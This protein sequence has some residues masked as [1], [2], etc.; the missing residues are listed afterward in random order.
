MKAAVVRQECDGQVEIK[1]IPLR[2]LEAGEALVEVEYCGLCHTD[3]HVAA[4]DFGKK[5]GRVIG[6]E[7]IGIVTKIAPDVKSLKIGD[8]VSIAWFHAGCGSCE[9]CISGQETFCRNVLNSGYSVDGGMAEQCIVKADYAVKV[10]EGLDPAQAT[11][12]TCAGVTTYKGIKVADTK[13]GQWLAVFGIGGL[14][15]LAVEYGKKVFNNKVVAISN[16]DSQ[17]ELCKELGADLLVNPKK[18][19]DVG[20][21]I[22]EHTGGGVHGAVV[23]SVTKTAFNQAIESVRPL[24]RVVALGLPS[25]TMDLSIPKTVLDGIQVLGSLVGTRQDLAEAFQ[26]SAEGKVVPI[27]EKRPL[28]D[29]NDMI[30]EMREGKIRGRMVVDMKMK[31]QK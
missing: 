29:I 14:G 8:R 2:P 1:D 26:F 6:H 28:E 9:Y 25:E 4:G 31:K 20:A 22:K 13:P 12:V 5:P 3:L 19:A 15:T 18:V 21:Y 17:L 7:G 23:T 11:S 10:P 16:S 30:N 27:V 24:G